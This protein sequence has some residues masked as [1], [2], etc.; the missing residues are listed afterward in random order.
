[1]RKIKSIFNIVMYVLFVI[2]IMISLT[3]CGKIKSSSSIVKYI[4]DEYNI[5]VE[6]VSVEGDNRAKEKKD[7]YNKFTLAEK[8]R[9]ITFTAISSYHSVGMDGSTFWYQESTSDDYYEK[10]T[11]SIKSELSNISKKYSIELE[12]LQ[13][14]ISKV[15]Y[16][17]EQNDIN[18]DLEN[19]KNALNEIMKVYN[20][21]KEPTSSTI[22]TILIY[23]NGEYTNYTCNYTANGA[24]VEFIDEVKEWRERWDIPEKLDT[25]V[26][27]YVNLIYSGECYIIDC[28]IIPEYQSDYYG[29][30]VTYIS[31][32]IRNDEAKIEKEY[33]FNLD[34]YREDLRNNKQIDMEVYVKDILGIVY[35]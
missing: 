8:D 6:V 3:G 4:K 7:R 5:D 33:R 20:L 11:E 14:M 23:I 30:E 17:T 2:G 19:I 25:D 35:Q 29:E 22:S 21:N 26:L 24:A 13:G 32:R 1:M 10:L 28:N 31:Y 12:Y 9:N 27:E 18:K 34:K 16:Y 15:D